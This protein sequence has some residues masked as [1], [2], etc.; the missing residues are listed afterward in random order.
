S[1]R[2][3]RAP[4]PTVTPTVPSRATR[5]T[6]DA[7]AR[8]PRALR[9]P[10][11]AT[12]ARSTAATA[13]ARVLTRPVTQAPSAEPPSQ[14]RATRR[15]PA[16]EPTPPVLPT[17]HNPTA[18]LAPT[19][20]SATAPSPAAARPP[21]ATPAIRAPAPTVTR[22]VPSPATKRTIAARP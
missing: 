19:A 8:I 22:T 11:T 18:R 17:R 5:R 6:I 13:P 7:P 16:P 20:C 4:G 9:V 2:A 14:G 12:S 21:P 3:I 15:K 10:T 1:T